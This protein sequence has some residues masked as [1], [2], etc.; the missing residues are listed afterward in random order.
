MRP[1]LRLLLLVPLVLTIAGCAAPTAPVAMSL[2]PLAAG[3]ARIV[4]YRDIGIYDAANVLSLALNGNAIGALPRG[5]VAYRDVAP[6]TYTVTFNPTRAAV[7][8]FPAVTVAAGDVAYMKILALPERDCAGTIGTF[9]GCD[10]N[11][12]IARAVAPAQA[13]QEIQG[14]RLASG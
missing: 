3:T 2:P 5:E 1:F 6:G 4:I 14:L 11:G 13:Q 9:G 7:N 12:F 10:I 8:Q